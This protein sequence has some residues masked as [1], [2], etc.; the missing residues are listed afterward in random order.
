[1]PTT[2][3]PEA[4]PATGLVQVS[5]QTHGLEARLKQC[6]CLP[7]LGV[8]TGL[9]LSLGLIESRTAEGFSLCRQHEDTWPDRCE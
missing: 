3:F 5:P 7:H 8:S 1:M 2:S 9:G 4:D 6:E